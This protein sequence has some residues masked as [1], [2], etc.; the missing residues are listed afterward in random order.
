MRWPIA[1]LLCALS[2]P[3]LGVM[4]TN[5]GT[6]TCTLAESGEE[7]AAPPSQQRAM[8]CSF[9]PSGLG[10]EESYSGEIRKVGSTTELDGKL[11]LI[12]AV[13]GPS[14]TA[15]APG[16]LEQSYVGALS[17]SIDGK[18]QRPKMLV[19]DKDANYGLRPMTDDSSENAA[20]NIT[21][22]TLKVKSIPT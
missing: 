20:G 9:K 1:A 8:I 12:W 19:G 4:Q 11:V 22:V 2:C 7:V 10:P 17:S 21:V 6:L 3:A 13:M 18:P 15:L 16:L 5:I 14:E